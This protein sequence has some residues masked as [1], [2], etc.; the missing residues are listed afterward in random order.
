V[1]EDQV[2]GVSTERPGWAQAKAASP[3]ERTNVLPEEG[4]GL[5]E[6]AA[7]EVVDELLWSDRWVPEVASL[8]ACGVDDSRLIEVTEVMDEVVGMLRRDPVLV[9]H[10]G[11]E[12]AG[13]EGDDD[14]GLTPNRCCE[15]V[16]VV[17]V[18]QLERG[19]EARLPGE[20][21]VANVGVHQ[22]PNAFNLRPGEVRST[23]EAAPHP[24]LVNV[25]APLGPVEVG[26]RQVHQEVSQRCRV[27]AS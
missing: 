10:V 26:E 7:L 3:L 21:T 16:A 9:E 19:D 14:V 12:V 24:L 15:H 18:R 8:T 2:S 25:V 6:A 22:F 13:V 5:N 27:E 1:F 23:P 11:W 17:R 4:G 20:E